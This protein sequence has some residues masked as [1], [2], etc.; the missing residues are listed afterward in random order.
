MVNRLQEM[1][2]VSC[3]YL[4]TVWLL[5]V[6]CLVFQVLSRPWQSL[7]AAQLAIYRINHALVDILSASVGNL[8]KLLDW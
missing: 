6:R 1:N 5:L 8:Q 2:Y 4:C 3:T 7:E